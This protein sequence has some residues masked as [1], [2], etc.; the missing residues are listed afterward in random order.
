[1]PREI[2]SRLTARTPI[3]ALEKS[4]TE[5]SAMS[6]AW[7]GFNGGPRVGGGRAIREDDSIVDGELRLQW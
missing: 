4:A 1:M 2:V 5:N 7:R 3:G 6:S